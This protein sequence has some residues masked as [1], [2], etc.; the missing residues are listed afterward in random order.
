M[1]G[2]A[3]RF[4][5]R[6]TVSGIANAGPRA[7]APSRRYRGAR[8]LGGVQAAVAA[9]RSRSHPRGHP[10]R[11]VPPAFATSGQGQSSLR[12]LCPGLG[13]EASRTARLCG[14]R[15]GGVRAVS[16]R[17]AGAARAAAGRPAPPCPV[18]AFARPASPPR[19]IP[20]RF[21]GPSAPRPPTPAPASPFGPNQ[22][23]GPAPSGFIICGQGVQKCWNFTLHD[24]VLRNRPGTLRHPDSG[25]EKERRRRRQ[26]AERGPGRGCGM[27]GGCGTGRAKAATKGASGRPVP[28]RLRARSPRDRPL[29]RVR[30]RPRNRKPRLGSR[31]ERSQNRPGRTNREPGGASCGAGGGAGGRV[32]L[33]WPA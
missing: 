5:A 12:S 23:S 7:G 11:A 8:R 22:G 24:H 18:G 16:P 28:R 2:A 19:V 14:L 3:V 15:L 30:A 31:A 9:S 32:L 26:A 33:E 6:A 20:H 17:P 21:G 25:R 10:R 1:P 29:R 4:P 27:R 13:C